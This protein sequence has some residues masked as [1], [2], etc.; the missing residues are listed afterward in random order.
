MWKGEVVDHDGEHYVVENA[1]LY[2]LPSSPP[3]ILV[4]GFGPKSIQ[5]AAR[6]GD[7]FITTMPS[8]DDLDSYRKHGGKGIAQ[9]GVKVCW[10]E[11]KQ[12]AVKIAHRTWRNSFVPGQLAQE[13]AMPTFFDQASELVTEEM[14]AEKVTCGSDVDE[15]VAT[16][17][18]YID[19][20]FDEVYVAQMGPDQEGMI[21]FY[22]RE[23]LPRLR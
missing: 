16:L 20:G 22:E 17:Q 15:H 14:V 23:V 19:A 1:Q 21:R 11:D 3:D 10:H 2:T 6:I 12:Q 4:S 8:R 13:L 9:S 5:V 7:G 18:E